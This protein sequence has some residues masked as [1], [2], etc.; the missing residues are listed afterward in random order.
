M[1]CHPNK[2]TYLVVLEGK[3]S[4]S[5]ITGQVE[6]RAAE[7]GSIDKGAFHQTTTISETGA[8]VMEIET[9]VNKRDLV[10]LK[11]KYGREG[12]G[13]ETEDQHSLET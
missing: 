6:R 5:T 9:P 10:R 7:G 3:V 12:Q 1:H 13:Y 8:F 11:D 4:C 2:T